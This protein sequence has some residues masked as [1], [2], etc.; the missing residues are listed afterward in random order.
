MQQGQ[1]AQV[2]EY[3]EQIEEQLFIA[4]YFASNNKD[5][6]FVD[7]DCINHMIHDVCFSRNWIS[8]TCPKLLL[9]MMKVL[10]LKPE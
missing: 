9:T 10:M 2:V 8:A 5:V 6:W 4:S 7:N 3:Q 1:Q